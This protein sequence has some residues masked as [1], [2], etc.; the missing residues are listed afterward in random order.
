MELLLRNPNDC[1]QFFTDQLKA[2]HE[3]CFPIRT[4]SSRRASNKWFTTEV[5]RALLERDL[6]YKDWKTATQD[7]KDLKQR[8]YKRLR[9]RANSVVERAKKTFLGG[10]LDANISSKLLWTRVKNLGAGKDKS[11][12][13]CDHDPDEVNRIFLSS[14]TPADS[15]N[16][17]YARPPPSPY[18][19][20]FR[21][22]QSW[23]VVNA[24]CEVKS[25]A[26]GMDDLPIRFLKI[27]LPLVIHQITHMF[28]LFIDTSTYPDLWKHAKVL[29]LKK[30]PNLNDVTNLRPISILC[31]LSKAF[32]KLLD[33]QMAYYID[34]NQLLTEY[35]AGFRQPPVV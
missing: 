27:A 25:N 29:P 9:N 20:S 13:Q 11:S 35:Q 16:Y 17:Q 23:E 24:V 3:F 2:V 10:Y 30:K 19:F 1:L 4:S 14:F 26:V 34:S 5:Q 15:A 18:N 8:T 21:N 28:N 7:E 12:Q 22:V 6:A 32:E 31:S 33:Q